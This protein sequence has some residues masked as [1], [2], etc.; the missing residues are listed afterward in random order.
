MEGGGSCCW[1]QRSALESAVFVS[2][3]ENKRKREARVRSGRMGKEIK[4]VGKG[5]EDRRQES[6]TDAERR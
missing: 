1:A 4:R 5:A 2:R 6:D 3:K